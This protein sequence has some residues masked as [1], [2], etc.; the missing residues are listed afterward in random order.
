MFG[1]STGPNVSLFEQFQKEWHTLNKNTYNPFNSKDIQKKL[2]TLAAETIVFLKLILNS[3]DFGPRNDYKEM[4]ELA[5]IVLNE[6]PKNFTFKS[7]GAYHH[8]RWMAKVIYCF[9]LYLF[10]QQLKL[11]SELIEKLKSFCLFA[12]TI[13]CKAW[14]TCTKTADAAYNDL[15]LYKNIIHYKNVDAKISLAAES[16]LKNH[17]WYLSGELIGFSLFSDNVSIIEKQQIIN[18]IKIFNEDWPTRDIKLKNVTNLSSKKLADL[19]TPSSISVLKLLKINIEVLLKFDVSVWQSVKEYDEAKLI[20]KSI[21]VTNDV[22]ER[23]VALANYFN[24]TISND[25]PEKQKV[26]QVIEY[27]RCKYKDFKKSSILNN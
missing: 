23:S 24:N 11:S 7:P 18:K 4:G 16:K 27:N 8:A 13:Y 12:S 20:I 21:H 5:L 10:R 6:K 9:K 22:A 14:L 26:L 25:E 1:Q 17:L 3:N 19:F 15:N 2:K